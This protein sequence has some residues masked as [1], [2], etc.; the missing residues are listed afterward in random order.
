MGDP[1]PLTG[2][3]SARSPLVSPPLPEAVR[4]LVLALQ[5]ICGCQRYGG[6]RQPCRVRLPRRPISEWCPGCVAA[7]AADA[8]SVREAAAQQERARRDWQPIE[9]APKGAELWFWVRPLT[10]EET[11][12]DTSGRPILSTGK[13]HLHRG[14]RGSWGSLFTATH[15]MLI[16]EPSA[17]RASHPPPTPE[18]K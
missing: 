6:G 12:T 8:L 3:D 15:W 1:F 10:A 17:P 11:Y 5:D 18:D 14:T 16:D 7:S 13:P 4:E 2:G 9:T